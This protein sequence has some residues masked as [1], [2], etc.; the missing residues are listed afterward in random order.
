MSLNPGE[1]AL[2]CEEIRRTKARYFR[3]ID[4]KDRELLSG[5]FTDDAVADYRGGATD[6]R[7]GVNAVPGATEEIIRG[8]AAIV[9]SLLTAVGPLTTVHQGAI[10]EITLRNDNEAA[11]I[12]PMS[13]RLIMP[14]GGEIR[15]LDGWGYYHEVYRR[16]DGEWKIADIRL[17]RLRL[18]IIRNN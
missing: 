16:E 11:A 4:T 13:D 15:A 18:D 14:E 8:R 9:D 6:P 3:G 1:I 2:A 12:F 7:T 10:P 17:S 5:V